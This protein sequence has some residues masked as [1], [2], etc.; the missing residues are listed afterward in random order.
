VPAAAPASEPSISLALV[1]HN[2][3]PVGNFGW[4]FADVFDRAYAPMVEALEGHPAIRASLHY[5]GPLIEWIRAERPAFLGRV[6]SL[7]ERGQVEVVGGGWFEPILASLPARDR[8][9]Q[10]ERM[11]DELE[12]TFGRRP[13]GAWLAE[14]V[15]EPSLPTALVGAGY[16]WTILDDE[17]FRAAGLPAEASWTPRVTEDQGEALAVFATDQGL[18]YAIPFADV[19]AA[20]GHLREHA[21]PDGDRLGMLGDDGEKF[22]GWPTTWDHCWGARHW[23]DRFFT[24][25][26]A[27]RSW[28]RTVTPS[29]WLDRHPPAG[30]VYVPTASYVEMT[31]WV[32]PADEAAEFHALLEADREAGRPEARWLRGGFWRNFAVKYREVNDLHKQM[33]RASA[34][35]ARMPP[36]PA[37]DRAVDELGRGQSNDAYWHGLFGGV[38]LTHLRVATFEHLIAAE[39]IADGAAASETLESGVVR[40]LDLDGRPEVLLATEGQLVTL[41]PAEGAGIGSWDVRA[42]RHPLLAVMRRR[43][44]SY[45]ETM[46]AAARAAAARATAA[47]LADQPGGVASIHEIVALKEPGLVERLHYDRYERRSGLVHLLGREVDAG[48][49]ET[50]TFDE[51]LDAVDGPFDLVDVSPTGLVVAR[52]AL[53]RLDDGTWGRLRVERTLGIGGARLD[54]W[55]EVE[56]VVTNGG[57]GPISGR[58]AVE[59][60][61][62]LLGGGANPDAWWEVGGERLPH[63]G[64]TTATRV[65]RL[66]QGNDWLGMAVETSVTPAADAWISPIETISNSESGFEAVYQGSCLVLSVPVVLPPGEGAGIR[67]RHSV[68]CAVDRREA[69]G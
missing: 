35:V 48:A 60:N 66:A 62:M 17:H 24:A 36:G 57:D 34:K 69:A 26:E 19:D 16:R 37:R 30:R 44:E 5:T 47:P 50:G 61:F 40:D 11:A 12:A 6:R 21:T 33:L 41:S 2:H 7:V 58:L 25:L 55:L 65:D 49:F 52:D 51:R 68:S 45:H 64:R 38:Y 23:V 29:D 20:I 18:R 63:D 43:R 39:D 46:L 9:I 1:F 27:E 54:P 3:Q 14:R 31:E 22:G 56:A 42:A 13:A 59:W 8:L 28:L 4:V 53:V 15:W 10:L 32:L 67:A